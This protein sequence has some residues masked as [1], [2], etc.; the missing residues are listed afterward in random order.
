MVCDRCILVVKEQLE[1]LGY[2]VEKVEL[3]SAF[4]KEDNPDETEIRNRL[5]KV[6]F[7]LLT[8]KQQKLS[9]QIKAQLIQYVEN[10]EK[11]QGK[12]QNI[13]DY[14]SS[15][16]PVSY[17]KLSSVFSENE[18]ITIEKYVIRL[19]I[20]K[21]KELVS[22]NEYTLSE[23]AAKLSYSSTAHLSN[24]FR[25]VTGMSVTDFKKASDSFR[26]PLDKLTSKD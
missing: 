14:L 9:E 10:L 20:E 19:K 13:S 24:Q 25:A 6:G 7:D 2:T 1:N 4:I 22:Y 16:I 18:G 8:S 26:K 17:S 11:V 5:T 21:V 23:I 15:E 3:G 12:N